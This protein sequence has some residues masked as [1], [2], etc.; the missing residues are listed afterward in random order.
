MNSET[1]KHAF[2]RGKEARA[3]GTDRGRC[4][5]RG[6]LRRLEWQ[7]GWDEQGRLAATDQVSDQQRDAVRAGLAALRD[8]LSPRP[9][10]AS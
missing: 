5:F 10:P 8:R 3:A 7:R 6:R 9:G 1:G 4:P 2:H